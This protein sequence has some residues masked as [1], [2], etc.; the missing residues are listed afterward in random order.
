MTSR[1]IALLAVVLGLLAWAEVP[2]ADDVPAGDVLPFRIL[3]GN[4]GEMP[5]DEVAC[6]VWN[7]G[8]RL[9]V[10]VTSDHSSQEI[11]GE[12]RVEPDGVLKDVSLDASTMRIRQ[13][14]PSV[15]RFDT[16]A[17]GSSEELSVVLAGDI[18]ILRVDFRVD[19]DAAPNAL[20]IGERQEKPKGLPA[21]LALTGARASWIERFGFN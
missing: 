15:L 16:E 10:R 7:E 18:E 2:R 11:A 9:H 4:P 14:V 8:G 12:L 20:H 6:F 13:P 17:G 19:G 5:A 1:P 21:D 3:Y